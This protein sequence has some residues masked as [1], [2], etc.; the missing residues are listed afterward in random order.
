MKTTPHVPISEL[1][2]NETFGS[3]IEKQ[4]PLLSVGQL[5]WR[6]NN[7]IKPHRLQQWHLRQHHEHADF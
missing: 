7:I 4:G 1:L 6:L 5:F 3:K 2:K